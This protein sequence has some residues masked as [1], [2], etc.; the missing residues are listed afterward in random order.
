MAHTCFIHTADYETFRAAARAANASEWHGFPMPSGRF[1]G[2][3]R[4]VDRF[5]LRAQGNAE[6]LPPA[7]SQTDVSAHA[8]ALGLPNAKTARDIYAAAFALHNADIFDPD[9]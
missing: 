2:I 4:N 9:L 5:A 1:L 7:H 3:V 6:L 8:K